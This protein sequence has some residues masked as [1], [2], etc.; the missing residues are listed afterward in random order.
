MIR[1]RLTAYRH[2]CFVAMFGLLGAVVLPVE[3]QHLNAKDALCRKPATT[4]EMTACTSEEWQAADSKLNA[5]YEKLLKGL[6]SSNGDNLRVAQQAWESYRKLDCNAERGLYDSGTAGS[7]N[8]NSCME[9]LATQRLAD[10]R[11]IYSYWGYG[12]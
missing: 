11:R 4:A 5:Y 8:Y 1:I 9:T 2:R 12:K 3:A 10:L 7:Y 6:D